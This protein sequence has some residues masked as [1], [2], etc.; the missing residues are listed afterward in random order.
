M[1]NYVLS[2]VVE[3]K[4]RASGAL[5]RVGSA[6][7]NVAQFAIG[8]LLAGGIRTVGRALGGLTRNAIQAV[9]AAQGL[10]IVIG[11]LR[12]RNS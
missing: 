7:G 10:E 8:D 11:Y 5:N 9:S 6:L 1:S 2:I 4:D 12:F 3:G